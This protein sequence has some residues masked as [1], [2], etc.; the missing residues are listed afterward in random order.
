MNE[1]FAGF[2]PLRHASRAILPSVPPAALILLIRALAPGDRT[3]ARAILEVAIYAIATVL[4]TWV[5]ERRL[6]K[7]LLGYFRRGSGREVSSQAL[8][9]GT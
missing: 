5:I 3:L 7:E 8:A 1:L 9:A 2:K 6:V 4:C